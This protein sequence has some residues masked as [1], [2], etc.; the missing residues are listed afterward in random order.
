M[1]LSTLHGMSR[2]RKLVVGADIGVFYCKFTTSYLFADM[3]AEQE[4]V[5]EHLIQACA[6]SI[7]TKES[8]R[9][10]RVHVT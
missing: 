1:I 8:L 5:D 7:R 4:N 3:H 10:V 9:E 2:W 6:L